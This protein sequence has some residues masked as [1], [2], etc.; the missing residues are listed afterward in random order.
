MSRHSTSR[1]SAPRHGL[2]ETPDAGDDRGR[3]AIPRPRT[4]HAKQHDGASALVSDGWA[5]HGAL[6][7]G[8]ARHTAATAAELVGRHAIEPTS[9]HA[10]EQV[11]RSDGA[12]SGSAFSDGAFSDGAAVGRRSRHAASEADAVAE[13]VTAGLPIVR[14]ETAATPVVPAPRRALDLEA[15]PPTAEIPAVHAAPGEAVNTDDTATAATAV[16]GTAFDGTVLVAGLAIP[17]PRTSGSP[18]TIALP[19][20]DTTRAT[21]RRA[22]QGSRRRHGSTRH[23]RTADTSR[24]GGR[25]RGRVLAG[26]GGSRRTAAILLT[27]AVALVALPT[28]GSAA[29][30][31][32]HWQVAA[33]ELLVSLDGQADERSEQL[34]RALTQ[35]G[36]GKELPAECA[37]PDDAAPVVQQPPVPHPS[38]R[39]TAPTTAP[40]AKPTP[41]P[42]KAPTTT[43]APPTKKAAPA[44]TAAGTGT[45]TTAAQQLGWGTP[46]RSD[47]F[48]AGLD[49][50][51][52][53]DGAG[54]GGNGRRTPDAVSAADG[55]L[56]ITGD[57]NG[58]S[59]GMSWGDGQKY[60]RWEARVRST[61]G[62]YH[63]V[64]LLWPTAENW[65]IGGEIDWMEISDPLRRTADT[66]LHYGANNNQVQGSVDVDATQWHNWAV[67]WS[68]QGVT[69]YLDGKVWWKTTTTSILP[70]GPMHMTIQ[71][72][73]F[74]GN[75]K[76][77]Q[78][79][80]DWVR[81]Y[82]I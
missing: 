29:V 22:P 69:T 12:F 66:F 56:T 19:G 16:D 80:V 75:P 76:S 34:R 41:A 1:S 7:E 79:Q 50:W 24:P 14:S 3:G 42:T 64:M 10:A 15:G 25:R 73:N 44:P 35:A 63:P 47:D 26:L 39:T 40:K 17:G 21:R 38:P 77:T 13:P 30:N 55:I 70:P 67:E 18:E 49:Q 11:E 46:T 2:P 48:S 65:P 60:G 51:G 31:Q 33:H 43:A 54:H 61:A 62:S 20:D 8:P 28:A 81:Q 23:G 36:V 68:P 58:N 32:C 37:G 9:R 27:A 78:M 59:G 82:G 74:G 45:G 4:P 5:R 71:L 57:E 6:D 72:D 53:Y 52:V